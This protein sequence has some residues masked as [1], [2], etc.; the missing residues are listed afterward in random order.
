MVAEEMKFP[1]RLNQS[2]ISANLEI[3]WEMSVNLGVA[4]LASMISD[5]EITA[6]DAVEASL[7]R[8]EAINPNINAITTVYADT[9]RALSAAADQR[10][11]DGHALGPCRAPK[12]RE[13]GERVRGVDGLR[14]V[15]PASSSSPAGAVIRVSPPARRRSRQPGG[16]AASD[17]ARSTAARIEPTSRVSPRRLSH[18]GGGSWTAAS[19]SPRLTC[20]WREL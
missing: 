19:A 15:P 20:A 8:I 9:A 2:T 12:G 11:A 4:A 18:P 16:Q 14:H 10:Q 5:R 13:P 6:S 7:E 17:S 1:W 3:T